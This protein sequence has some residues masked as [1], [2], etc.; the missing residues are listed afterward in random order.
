MIEKKIQ[1]NYYLNELIKR[2]GNGL[3][4]IVIEIKNCGKSYLLRTLFK[5]NHL[6]SSG[7]ENDHIIEMSFD[8]YENEEYRDPKK[9]YPWAI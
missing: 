7:V 5:K 6:T 8:L 2:N 4:K 9:F 1:K 3:I